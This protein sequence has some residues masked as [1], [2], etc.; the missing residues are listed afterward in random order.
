M[1]D[2]ANFLSGRLLDLNYASLLHF[3]K[4]RIACLTWYSR[5]PGRYRIQRIYDL[6]EHKPTPLCRLRGMDQPPSTLDQSRVESMCEVRLGSDRI[7]GADSLQTANRS[8]RACRGK[9]V[10]G[11]T[12]ATRS[13]TFRSWQPPVGAGSFRQRRSQRLDITPI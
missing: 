4:F 12:N 9:R 8:S 6:I 2:L 13:D 3:G 10:V 5:R 11:S 1:A 7:H